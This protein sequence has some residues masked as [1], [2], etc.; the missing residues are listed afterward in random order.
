MDIWSMLG[1]APE[2]SAGTVMNSEPPPQSR[3]PNPPPAV[4]V[5]GPYD[6]LAAS[7]VS[8]IHP[9]AYK[10]RPP[11]IPPSVTSALDANQAF[12]IGSFYD[13]KEEIEAIDKQRAQRLSKGSK[14]EKSRDDN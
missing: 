11:L 7:N 10:F 12:I 5:Q 4:R 3:K 14:L 13:F 1:Y 6:A 8:L 2:S 9:A